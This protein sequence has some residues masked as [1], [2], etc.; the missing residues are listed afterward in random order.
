MISQHKRANA[1]K[2]KEMLANEKDT[3]KL[4]SNV[5]PNSKN[6]LSGERL[7]AS[8]SMVSANQ[9][10]SA[11]APSQH[12]QAHPNHTTNF[13]ATQ[14]GL[15]NPLFQLGNFDFSRSALAPT[16]SQNKEK[17]PNMHNTTRPSDEQRKKA[18]Q[19]SPAAS[20]DPKEAHRL[21]YGSQNMQQPPGNHNN[22][23]NMNM[24]NQQKSE[25]AEKRRS[26]SRSP[27]SRKLLKEDHPTTNRNSGQFNMGSSQSINLTSPH[28]RMMS[29]GS[30]GHKEAETME[31]L[32]QD[33]LR[34][35]GLPTVASSQ[36]NAL[37]NANNSRVNTN[38]SFP[39]TGTPTMQTQTK[40]PISYTGRDLFAANEPFER[41]FNFNPNV[42]NSLLPQFH[43]NNSIGMASLGASQSGNNNLPF[44]PSLLADPRF[45]EQYRLS[46]LS[47]EQTRIP[48]SMESLMRSN[49]PGH[50]FAAN[51]TNPF[52][53]KQHQQF[54]MGAGLPASQLMNLA[55][56]QQL[57]PYP[58]GQH[59]MLGKE[60]Q[61]HASHSMNTAGL[62]IMPQMPP[63]FSQQNHSNSPPVSA[64]ANY[65]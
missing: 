28:S 30:G 55:N 9:L 57:Q 42:A 10:P 20:V 27:L 54:P 16:L 8:S 29:M 38:H 45:A 61:P 22:L 56:M 60:K 15:F 1:S 41:S 40:N 58:F 18:T 39:V 46:M 65:K 62:N 21:K 37:L 33:Y 6:R 50:G 32:R 2:S 14:S 26:R 31:K 48:S 34:F 59:A 19:P 53:E 25:V 35:N 47:N 24:F 36:S 11:L 7:A 17:T 3:S 44:P 5:A 13:A 23:N 51:F 63:V 43:H 64:A 4:N 12:H 49:V 52:F